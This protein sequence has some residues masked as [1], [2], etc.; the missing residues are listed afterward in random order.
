LFQAALWYTG[1]LFAAMTLVFTL[2]GDRG[3]LFHSTGALLPF[4]YAA[5]PIGLDAVIDWIAQ[6]RST[7]NAAT[8]KQV[9]G[10]AFVV[11]AI[12]LSF[13]VYRGRVIGPDW[14]NPIWN[15]ADQMNAAIG[16]WL[17]DRGEVNPIV[18]VNN[19]PGF[20]YQ[21][22]FSSIV[23]PYGDVADLL[24]AADQFSARWLVLDA[25]R[26]EQ[27]AAIFAGRDSEP[28]LKMRQAIGPVQLYEIMPP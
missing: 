18:L 5:V 21:T 23:V 8:A 10:A 7:W 2:A 28:R 1:L 16:Q 17:T 24:S 19:P 25:N 12:A 11:Y 9:F 22:G 6:R 20:T 27:L 3:G 15:Q 4:F 13:F 26:P 14:N